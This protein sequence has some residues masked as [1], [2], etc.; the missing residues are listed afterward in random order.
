MDVYTES[1]TVTMRSNSKL[2]LRGKDRGRGA[3]LVA[4][5]RKCSVGLSISLVTVA[6]LPNNTTKNAS[7]IAKY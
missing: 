3:D 2:V 1:S 4:K 7:Q 5:L 6:K